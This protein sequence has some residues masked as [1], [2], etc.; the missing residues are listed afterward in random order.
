MDPGSTAELNFLKQLVQAEFEYY[1]LCKQDPLVENDFVNWLDQTYG[2]RYTCSDYEE[3]DPQ[4]TDE[5]KYLWFLLKFPV[6]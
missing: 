4:I 2:I 6:G 5:I 3:L 1:D